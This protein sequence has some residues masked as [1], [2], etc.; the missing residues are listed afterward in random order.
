MVRKPKPYLCLNTT[1]QTIYLFPKKLDHSRAQTHVLELRFEDGFDYRWIGGGRFHSKSGYLKLPTN[2]S[3]KM[4]SA[5]V[6]D[7]EQKDWSVEFYFIQARKECHLVLCTDATT[8]MDDAQG[9]QKFMMR[10]LH[11]AT[12][13]LLKCDVY[14][15]WLSSKYG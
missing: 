9:W 3:F 2:V 13:M 6:S 1:A 10:A 7:S 5:R 8:N 12:L 11:Q 14:L 4:E 15:R